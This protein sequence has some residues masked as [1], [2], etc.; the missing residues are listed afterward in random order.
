MNTKQIQLKVVLGG[1]EQTLVAG[2]PVKQTKRE[3]SGKALRAG[4]FG[5]FM[6]R[7]NPLATY[8]DSLCGLLQC[9]AAHVWTLVDIDGQ[10]Y[11]VEGYRVV[12]RLG[13]FI[14]RN[15]RAV[16]PPDGDAYKMFKY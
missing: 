4:S 2:K 13:Y 3:S 7:F 6:R 5:E 10:A 16:M 8:Q 12:N 9:P 14:A 1:E 11:L 15:P